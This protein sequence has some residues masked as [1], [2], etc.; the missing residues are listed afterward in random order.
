MISL[1]GFLALAAVSILIYHFFFRN[2]G[3]NYPKGPRAFPLL[4]NMLD[5]KGYAHLKLNEWADTYGDVYQIWFAGNRCYVI[6]DLKLIKEVYNDPIFAGRIDE[7]SF[8]LFSDGPHGILNSQGQEWAEQRRFTLRHLRDFGFGK[9]AGEE[10]IMNEVNEFLG[11]LSKQ[12]GQPIVL[13]RTFQMA[14][15]NTL[16]EIMAGERYEQDDPR[17]WAVF[18]KNKELSEQLGRNMAILFMPKLAKMLPS[19]TGWN[20]LISLVHDMR[21]ITLGHVDH[22]KKSFPENGVPR[23][24][25]DAYLKE[26]EATKDPQ[27]S[28]YKENGIRSLSAVI[29][30]LFAAGFET[31]T[32]TIS[33]GVLY[34]VTFTEVQKKLQEELDRVVGRNRHPALADRQSLPF[35]EGT[36]TETLRYSSIVPFN[37]FHTATQDAKLRG[38]DVP[39]GTWIISTNHRVHFDERYF[40]NPTKFDPSRFISKDG[41]FQ[42]PD[43][44]MAFG[45]GKRVCLGETLARDEVFLFLTNLF[46][47]YNIRMADENPNPTFDPVPGFLLNPQDY[48]VV[49]TERT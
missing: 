21:G 40:P 43:S 3:K 41:K 27:S 35:V 28:F 17:L 22:H 20:Q 12:V 9:N 45:F 2:D 46:H 24:F 34:L 8:T 1:T 48:K 29:G 10:L 33:W 36:I 38:Y 32:S 23:D 44:L 30:D 47:R 42:K 5:L 19:I 6:N 15:L 25:I 37:V 31:V 26:I 13:N 7:E 4:G 18:K 14:V 39:K 11:K 16:W 49:M